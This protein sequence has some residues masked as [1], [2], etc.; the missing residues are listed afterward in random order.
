MN[1]LDLAREVGKILDL[2]PGK[3]GNMIKATNIVNAVLEAIKN[4]LRQGNNIIVPGFGT[5]YVR[6]LKP[7]TMP[8]TMVWSS[9]DPK[10]SVV[11]TDIARPVPAV[12]RAAFRPSR[13]VTAALN[14]DHPNY[15]ESKFVQKG[16]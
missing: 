9:K 6:R 3:H 8:H 15:H 11:N 10:P 16:S 2:P 4:Q 14:L 7:K 5:F 12:R 13:Y 1:K